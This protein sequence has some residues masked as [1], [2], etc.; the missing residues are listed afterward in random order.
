MSTLFFFNSFENLFEI[1]KNIFEINLINLTIVLLII[2]RFLGDAVSSILFERKKV[3][4]ITLEQSN[5]KVNL[6]KEKLIRVRLK[7]NL[8][9]DTIIKLYN[10]R[11]D[12]FCNKKQMVLDQV[13]VYFMQLQYSKQEILKSRTQKVLVDIYNQIILLTFDKLFLRITFT[14][15]NNYDLYLIN[16]ITTNLYM[17]RFNS[18]I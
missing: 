16:R 13:N 7:L 1:N 6:V 5:K 17:K 15:K 18:I 11:F 3:I 14:I 8:T 9:Q 12:L 2:F 10:K 4:D